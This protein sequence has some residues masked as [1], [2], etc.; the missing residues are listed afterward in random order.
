MRSWFICWFWHYIYPHCLLIYLASPT[1][2]FLHLFFLS[3]LLPYLPFPLTL[4]PLRFQA[5]CR[6]RRLNPAL[7]FC[8]YFVL[9]Y[10]SFDWNACF[11]CVRFSF[12]YQAKRLAWETSLKWLILCQVGH[13]ILTRINSW[14]SEF[15]SVLVIWTGLIGPLCGHSWATKGWQHWKL[16]LSLTYLHASM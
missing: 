16:F 10:I 3:Y 12:P 11:C 7:V 9:L 1:S 5:G 8:V 13:K 14:A 6:K 15:S 2:F 4:G